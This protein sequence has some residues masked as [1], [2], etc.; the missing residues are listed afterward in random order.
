MSFEL[1]LLL[2]ALSDLGVSI[3]PNVLPQPKSKM[4]G[5]LLPAIVYQRISTQRVPSHDGT[6]LVGALYQI[7]CWEARYEDAAELA[8]SVI[9]ALE[10]LR[11]D[12]G[13]AQIV[14]TRDGYEAEPKLYFRAIDVRLWAGLDTELATTS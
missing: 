13:P 6:S 9:G 14:N 1:E 3:Y 5:Y 4:E 11:S 2:P 7:V 10:N 12:Q 8:Q